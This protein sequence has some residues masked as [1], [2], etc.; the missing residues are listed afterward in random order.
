MFLRLAIGTSAGS[1]SCWPTHQASA[2][3]EDADWADRAALDCSTEFER[4]RRYQSAKTR[5]LLRSLDTL[6]RMREFGICNGEWGRRQ[7]G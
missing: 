7:G 6:R 2:A 1:R 5:E 4:H 3:A